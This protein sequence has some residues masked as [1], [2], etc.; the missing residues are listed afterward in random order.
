MAIDLT[1]F[2]STDPE[3]PYIHKPFSR[4]GYTWATTGHILVRVPHD[5]AVP[6]G[7]KL[8]CEKVFDPGFKTP[9]LALPVMEIPQPKTDEC[10]VCEGRGHA[11]DCPDCTCACVECDGNGS[12]AQRQSIAICGVCFDVKYIRKIWALPGLLV[13]QPD[14]AKAMSFSFDGGAGLLMPLSEPWEANF[15]ATVSTAQEA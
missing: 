9:T 13:S 1:Q 8:A 5:P 4:A 10:E 14:A 7:D 11:H 12:I 15:T 3:R 2:C 6:N